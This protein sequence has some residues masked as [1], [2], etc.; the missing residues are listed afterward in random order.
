[1]S[2][3]NSKKLKRFCAGGLPIVRT[4]IERLGLKKILSKYIPSHD[5]ETIPAVETLILLI[6]NLILGKAPLY[7]LN[8]WVDGLDKRALGCE[9]ISGGKFNDDRFGRALDKLYFADRASL[10]T[11]I[12][13]A[14]IDKFGLDLSQVH[15]DSTTIKAYGS[16]AGRTR[17]GLELARGHS[18]D[19]RPDLKQLVYNMTIAADGAVPIHCHCYPGNRTDDTVHIE[20]WEKICRLGNGVD[21]LYVADSKL[22]TDKQLHYIDSHGGRAVTIMPATWNEAKELDNRLRT[23]RL[24]KKEILRKSRPNSESEIEYF[25]AYNGEYFTNKRG[26]RIHLIHSSEKRKRDRKSRDQRLEKAEH[27]LADLTCKINQRNLKTEESIEN[28]AKAILDKCDVSGLITLR[29]NTV[30]QEEEKQIG[31]GRPG[32]NTK[33]WTEYTEYY[34]LGWSRHLSVIKKEARTDGTFP[35]VST[36]INLT[37]KQVLEAYKY[38]PRIEKRFCQ[39]K[40]YHKAAPLL[41]KKIERVEANLFAFFLS[42]I[43][44]ALI[45]REVRG[46]MKENRIAAIALYPEDRFAPHPTTT[47]ILRVFENICRAVLTNEDGSIDEFKDDLTEVQVK[48]LELM[49]MS[50]ESFW[51]A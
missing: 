47:K 30:Q 42:L 27:D 37:A 29:I 23:T 36:D 43:I 46:K 32:K 21:F 48:I 41:F 16:I 44:Q 9:G 18:K 25:S 34:T 22:C 40:W 35:L 50:E 12:I 14:A 7:E 8:E 45:E 13:V 15:N 2:S 4:V 10:M 17:D 49:E 28:A 38:Q 5:N 51:Y 11:E 20:T 3:S 6:Y 31:K 24:S 1:M 39:F 33:Y 26:Y 19:H